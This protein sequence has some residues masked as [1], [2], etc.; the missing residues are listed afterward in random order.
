MLDRYAG[1]TGFDTFDCKLQWAIT[2]PK[3][4]EKPVLKLNLRVYGI[5]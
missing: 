4:N 2:V 5:F 3:T 1:K